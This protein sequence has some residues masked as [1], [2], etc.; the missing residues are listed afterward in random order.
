MDIE[1]LNNH[2]S[3]QLNKLLTT[4]FCQKTIQKYEEGIDSAHQDL[5]AQEICKE[6]ETLVFTDELNSLIKE[7]LQSDFKPMW[8]CFDVVNASA[9]NYYYNVKWHLDGGVKN[10]MKIFIYLNSV[11]EHGGNTAIIDSQRTKKLTNADALPLAD[12]KRKEDL[13]EVLKSIG[14]DTA[15][16]TYDLKAG[17]GLLFHPLSLAHKCIPPSEGNRRYTVCFSIL[18]V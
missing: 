13:S 7:H 15:Y 16:L 4:D 1:Y 12:E 6:C 9:T 10:T 11:C 17:D 8:P 2:F 14:L 3:I 5:I 18:P